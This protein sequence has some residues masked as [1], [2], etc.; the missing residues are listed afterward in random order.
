MT[1][2]D[3]LKKQNELQNSDDTMAE[4]MGKILSGRSGYKTVIEKS[5]PIPRCEGCGLV[6]AGNEKFCPECGKKI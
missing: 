6:L 2:Y 4:L 1:Q 3:R 5:K